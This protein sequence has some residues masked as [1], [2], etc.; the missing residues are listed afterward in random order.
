[1]KHRSSL[2]T[3]PCVA[4]YVNHCKINEKFGGVKEEFEIF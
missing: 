4:N 1:V 2:K 3:N